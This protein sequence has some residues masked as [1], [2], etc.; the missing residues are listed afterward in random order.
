VKR[1]LTAGWGVRPEAVDVIP[2]A[3]GWR[4]LAAADR[5]LAGPRL[6]FFGRIWP[7]KGLDHLLAAEP[8]VSERFPDLE[9]V[10]A[11]EGEDFARYRRLMV[12]P[13]RYRVEYGHISVEHREQLFEEAYAVVLPYV[14]ATQTGVVPLAYRHAKPVIAT[15]VGGLPEVVADGL[16]GYLVPPRDP[17]AL[18]AA[19]ERALGDRERWAAMGGNAR[20][21]FESTHSPQ[22]TALATMRAYERL[23]DAPRRPRAGRGAR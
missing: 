17:V 4:P 19:L 16:T 5:V 18:A 12:H 1:T 13:E 3:F 23:L 21:A 15:A 2:L 11:G 14:E 10:I 7:Y 20:Q 9:I 6:L 22:A 8:I